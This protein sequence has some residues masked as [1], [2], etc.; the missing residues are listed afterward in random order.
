MTPPPALPERCMPLRQQPTERPYSDAYHLWGWSEMTSLTCFYRLFFIFL[1]ILFSFFRNIVPQRKMSCDKIC[2]FVGDKIRKLVSSNRR[3][4]T[5]MLNGW[6][7]KKIFKKIFLTDGLVNL[8]CALL[9]FTTCKQRIL[10]M[11]GEE[12]GSWPYHL[13]REALCR[14]KRISCL[15]FCHHCYLCFRFLISIFGFLL[16]LLLFHSW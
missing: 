2:H 11:Q 14:R 8:L 13:S 6:H 1:S 7:F 3:F 12:T 15:A 16:G 9:D 5:F 10:K 4:T